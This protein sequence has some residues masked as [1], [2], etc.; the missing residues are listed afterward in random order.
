MKVVKA[1][2]G[3]N[4]TDEKS[5][6]QALNTIIAQLKLYAY[7][8]SLL[9]KKDQQLTHYRDELKQLLEI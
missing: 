5:W 2:Y 4:I 3:I 9:L 8:V 6:S 1:T 7:E